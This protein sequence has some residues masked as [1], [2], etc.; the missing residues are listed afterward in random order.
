MLFH[1][2]HDERGNDVESG[3]Q[4][5]QDE[6]D[7][8]GD[9]LQPEGAEEVPVHL[10]PVFGPEREPHLPSNLST[11][12]FHF[13]DI[14]GLDLN[15]CDSGSHAEELL[16]A[17]KRDIGHGVIILI[18]PRVKNS[19]HTKALHLGHH[20]HGR[21]GTQRRDHLDRIVEGHPEM[22]R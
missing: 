15:P 16:S 7:E 19:Y 18:H 1:H 14:I 9:L 22:L 6:D 13:I 8:H 17:F 10:H 11:D 20:P 4:D 12:L 3:Y 21:H 5:D 2:H